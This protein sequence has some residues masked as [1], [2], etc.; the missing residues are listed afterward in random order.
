MLKRR[1]QLTLHTECD[2]SRLDV[3]VDGAS[4][5]HHV[6]VAFVAAGTVASARP[7]HGLLQRRA[8]VRSV[9]DVNSNVRAHLLFGWKAIGFHQ[10]LAD[11]DSDI[12]DITALAVTVALSHDRRL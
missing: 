9:V 5:Q 12:V 3:S 6:H 1:A 7:N 4:R 2:A 8:L 11:D 10:T